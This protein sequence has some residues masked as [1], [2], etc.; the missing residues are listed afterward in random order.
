[1]L[2]AV[3]FGR[4][5]TKSSKV[6]TLSCVSVSEVSAWMVIGTSWMLSARRSA[7]TTTS[8]SSVPVPV[9]VAVSAAAN[10]TALAGALRIAATAAEILGLGFIAHPPKGWL[11]FS[12]R[13]RAARLGRRPGHLL[14]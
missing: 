4:Y 6:L 11:W 10:T 2:P 8:C 7:V 3:T 1:M 9:A 14:Y 5:F 13:T 12:H